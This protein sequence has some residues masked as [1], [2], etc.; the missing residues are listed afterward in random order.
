MLI[1]AFLL[2]FAT[3]FGLFAWALVRFWA[4]PQ[5]AVARVTG[6]TV[7]PI[8]QEKSARHPSLAFRELLNRLGQAIPTNPKDVT[9]MQR[10]LIR[11]GFR[12]DNALRLLYGSKVLLAIVFPIAMTVAVSGSAAE[13]TN[14]IMV[15]LCS[16]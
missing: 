6:T 8:I 2:V 10:R 15:V 5:G 9:T 11:A 3:V 16:I 4:R 14:K 7:K 1:A 13:T 12:S